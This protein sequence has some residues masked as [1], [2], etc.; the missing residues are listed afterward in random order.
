MNV[1]I[2]I[3]YIYINHISTSTYIFTSTIYLHHPLVYTNGFYMS[4]LRG[5]ISNNQ[6]FTHFNHFNHFN[7]FNY[8]SPLSRSRH[9]LPGLSF[10]GR[11]MC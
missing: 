6:F 5:F 4:P 1:F 11:A 9:I 3:V 7:Y 2:S 10:D 8:F